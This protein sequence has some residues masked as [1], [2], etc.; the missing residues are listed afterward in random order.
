[1]KYF[2][3]TGASSGIGYAAVA[4]LLERGH[5]VFGSVR[6]CADADRLRADFGENFDALLFDVTDHTALKRATAEVAAVVGE[7]GLAG[8]VNNAGY[9]ASGPI[10][11]LELD[12]FR[13]QFEVNFFGQIAVMQSLLPLLGARKS[14][15]Y[16]PGRIVNISSVSGKFGTP[17]LAPYCASKH[18]LEALSDCLRRE[19]MLYGV[20]VIVIEPG[21]IKTPIW[22]KA[23]ELD[24][25]RFRTT[26]YYDIVVGLRKYMVEIG[27]KS[28]PVA[29]VTKAILNALEDPKPKCRVALPNNGRFAWWLQRALPARFVDRQ[30]AKRLGM[31]N[32]RAREQEG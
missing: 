17:F 11:H 25:E 16:P 29:V 9:A 15:P 26:D 18:A 1:M 32:K 8:L 21:S 20:D 12:E 2:V 6:T 22:D 30:I 19:L 24:A 23:E 13:H 27:R 28:Q 3:V 31:E 7:T 4:G 14:C 5:H 10:M